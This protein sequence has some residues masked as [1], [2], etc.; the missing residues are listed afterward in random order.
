MNPHLLSRDTLDEVTQSVSIPVA[1]PDGRLIGFPMQRIRSTL[2]VLLDLLD[3]ASLNKKGRLKI[4]RI[5]AAEL[6]G[7]T[8]WR[9]MGAQ[10]LQEFAQ[11]LRGFE[12]I[13]AVQPPAGL[14]TQLR[15]YQQEGLSWLQFLRQYELSGILADDM[16]LGKTVQALAHLLIEK[17]SGRMDRPSLVVGPTSLMTNW[18]QEAERF[19]PGLKVLVLHGMD[20]KQHFE[21]IKESDLVITSYPLLARDEAIWLKEEFHYV[22]LDEAQYIKNAKTTYAQVACGLKARLTS[23]PHRHADGKS[24][25]ANS[26]RSSIFSCRGSSAMSSSSTPFS[27]GPLKS[28]TRK[29]GASSWPAGSLPS[30]CVA[31][32]GSCQRTP[33]QNRDPAKGGAH[34]GATRPLRKCAS[35]HA[36]QGQRRSRPQRHVPLAHCDSRCLAQ[37]APNLLPSAVA[38]LAQ[39][40]ESQRIGQTGSALGP[41]RK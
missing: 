26:G 8:D 5:R 23:L 40:K 31:K 28:S 30:S 21:R 20:R 22:I 35:G 32:R 41:A 15:P 17:E 34:F 39:R 4:S 13:Q 33:S 10:E 9:W 16:G 11:R 38:L 27:V 18:R 12:G 25:R 7:E 37:A 29:I 2:G 24:L 3:P 36:R 1:L 19:A 6:A 14:Q